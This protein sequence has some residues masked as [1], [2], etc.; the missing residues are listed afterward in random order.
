MTTLAIL[1]AT[2]L[3]YLSGLIG[4][5]IALALVVSLTIVNS[6][7]ANVGGSRRGHVPSIAA[8]LS[9][10]A[11]STDPVPPVLTAINK[12]LTDLAG[13]LAAVEGHMSVARRVFDANAETR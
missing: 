7:L 13:V 9:A 3:G 8:S 2:A 6:L 1:D 12:E 11:E 10:V 5:V 4:L